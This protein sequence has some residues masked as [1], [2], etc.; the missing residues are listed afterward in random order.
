M[1]N[2]GQPPTPLPILKSSGMQGALWV[3]VAPCSTIESIQESTIGPID[4][5]LATPPLQF[6]GFGELQGISLLPPHPQIRIQ[7]DDCWEQN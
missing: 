3:T 7:R 5:Y 2:F 6:P 4:R 1:R